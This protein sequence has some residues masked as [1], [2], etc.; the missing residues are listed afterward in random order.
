MARNNRFNPRNN[1]DSLRQRQ[2]HQRQARGEQP[3][4]IQGIRERNREQ[5]G[6]FG[7]TT[8]G[9]NL[10][11]GY[12][13]STAVNNNLRIY[14]E[15]T[16]TNA[17]RAPPNNPPTQPRRIERTVRAFEQTAQ[18]PVPPV[19]LWGD[20]LRDREGNFDIGPDDLYNYRTAAQINLRQNLFRRTQENDF[21]D[22]TTQQNPTRNDPVEIERMNDLLLRDILRIPPLGD[23]IVRPEPL[24]A[25]NRFRDR[26]PGNKSKKKSEKFNAHYLMSIAME[27]D[28]TGN[29]FKFVVDK[30]AKIGTW[31][32]YGL[33]VL[34]IEMSERKT[35]Q[36]WYPKIPPTLYKGKELEPDA[37]YNRVR[38][39]WRHL[40]FQAL[41]Y[42]NK[43]AVHT[44][45]AYKIL[46][47][48]EA[49]KINPCYVKS[50]IASDS[51]PIQ[52]TQGELFVEQEYGFSNYKGRPRTK[53]VQWI[54]PQGI[55]FQYG[56]YSTS[57][58]SFN[59]NNPSANTGDGGQGL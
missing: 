24:P 55:L 27:L 20:I 34:T 45:S 30:D 16:Y 50:F 32:V 13:A 39:L 48:G 22:V 36:I 10:G 46:S 53:P 12:W 37:V 38:L 26:L 3:L 58:I 18:A 1:V 8:T 17:F 21:D 9:A 59:L 29:V 33:K 23:N 5:G 54:N 14:D 25:S 15:T 49:W 57:E 56:R 52:M 41:R 44:G 47:P 2:D 43:V 7:Y 4:A 40:G 42:K 35:N 51:D 28:Y 6:N 31:Y 11:T 19:P